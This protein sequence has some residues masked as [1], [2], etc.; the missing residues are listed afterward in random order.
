MTLRQAVSDFLDN[1]D[2]TVENA[3]DI[4]IVLGE[5]FED[6]IEEWFLDNGW[7][8]DEENNRWVRWQ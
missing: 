4:L 5:K 3:D 7:T 2:V 8:Y 6:A 1:T